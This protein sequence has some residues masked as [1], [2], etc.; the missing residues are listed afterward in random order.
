M[1]VLFGRF[2]NPQHRSESFHQHRDIPMMQ[3]P[4]NHPSEDFHMHQ[5]LQ[6]QETLPTGRLLP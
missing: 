5:N 6:Q 4:A 1:G 3:L 2:Q